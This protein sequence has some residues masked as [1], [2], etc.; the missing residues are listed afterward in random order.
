MTDVRK[1]NPTYASGYKDQERIRSRYM[2][3]RTYYFLSAVV[4]IVSLLC[5]AFI[6]NLNQI[7]KLTT[8]NPYWKQFLLYT[9]L[10]AGL[11][12]ALRLRAGFC[13]ICSKFK[14]P[15]RLDYG[16]FCDVCGA[17]LFQYNVYKTQKM[18]KGKDRSEQLFEMASRGNV[19]AIDTLVSKGANLNF[20]D[21]YGNTSLMRAAM[22]NQLEAMEYIVQFGGD[23][24]A[25]NN[26]GLNA[27][28]LAVERGHFEAAEKLLEFGLDTDVS[29]K[30]G[31]TV[32]DF[33]EKSKDQKLI[34]LFSG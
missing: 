8:T 14:R 24:H 4:F 21:K 30:D 27:L 15:G 18:D 1:L 13:T 23:P 7:G 26:Y 32:K 2:V 34:A 16:S 33:A 20:K 17:H 11:A 6:L 29:T 12:F 19:E 10:L 22:E 31:R 3:K 25:C 5:L 9:G 28:M